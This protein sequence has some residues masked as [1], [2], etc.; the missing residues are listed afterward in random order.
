[1]YNATTTAFP[2]TTFTATNSNAALPDRAADMTI[3]IL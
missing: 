1:M 3:G 2:N